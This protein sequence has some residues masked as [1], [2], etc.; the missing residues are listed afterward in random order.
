MSDDRRLWDRLNAAWDAFQHGGKREA[1]SRPAVLERPDSP[2]F[3]HGTKTDASDRPDPPSFAH[4][5]QT[6]ASD[7]PPEAPPPASDDRG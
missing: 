6:D 5:T 1:A 4:G 7:R 3:A 2:S